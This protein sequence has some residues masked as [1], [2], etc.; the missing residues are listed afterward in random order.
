MYLHVFSYLLVYNRRFDIDNQVYFT[1]GDRDYS[2][3]WRLSP[4]SDL[5][6]TEWSLA[7]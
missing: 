6:I 5:N 3:S 1:M 4:Y 2:E 7:S